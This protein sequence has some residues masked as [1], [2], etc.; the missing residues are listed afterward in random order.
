MSRRLMLALFIVALCGSLSAAAET[1]QAGV[2]KVIITPD[3]PM[4]LS[5]YSSRDKPAEG[6]IH[7]LWAK[8]LALEDKKGKRC[9]LVTMDLVGIPRELSVVVCKAIEKKHGLTREAVMLSVSHTHSGPVV[10]SNL[11]SMYFLDAEQEKR[12]EEYT[13]SLQ[14]KLVS[15][16]GEALGCLKPAR[17]EWSNGHASFAV[18]RRNNKEPE[19]PKLRELGQLKG[20]VDHDVPVLAVRDP[21]GRLKAIAFGYACHATVLPFYQWCGDYPGFAQLAVE[22]AHPDADALFWAG[23]GGDQ[24]PLPRRSVALSEEYGKRLADAVEAVVAGPMTPLRG[25]LAAAYAEIPLSFADLPSREQLVRD[26]TAKDK[27]VA[28][29][30]R[31]LLRRIEKEGSLSGTYPYPVQTWQLGE[32]DG[33][34]WVALGGEVVVDYSLRLKRELGRGTTWVAGYTNDVMAY[35]PSLRVLKEGG[36]EGGGAMVYYGQPTTWSPRVEETIVGAVR[37]QVEKLRR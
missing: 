16:V 33:L 35:I 2:A 18:N 8:A 3:K 31:L 32:G 24:N 5:G 15:V 21:E 14:G 30:A 13:K 6:K 27:Y 25:G 26:T 11:R 7:D 22:K 4:W 12:V 9:V 23:C 17:V 37:D 36:Y 28:E 20:P 29:R 10:G 1:W 19:V 34:T